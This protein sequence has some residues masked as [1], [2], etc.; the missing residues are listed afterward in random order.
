MVAVGEPRLRI[1]RSALGP[2]ATDVQ[3]AD[4]AELGQNP[5]RIIPAWRDFVNRH[6]GAGHRLRG[7]SEP[8]W[9]GRS[10]A[11]VIE[12]QLHEA[13]LNMAVPADTPLWLLC[14]YDVA[15]LDGTVI[16]EAHRSHPVVMQGVKDRASA[17]YGGAS[18]VGFMFEGALPAPSAS[19]IVV[20]VDCH[21]HGHVDKVMRHARTMGLAADR[22]VRLAA[23]VDEIAVAG[24]R[25][26]GDA[27]IRVWQEGAAVVCQIT[28]GGVV[29]NPMIGRSTNLSGRFSRNRAIR[30]ANELCDLVQVRSNLGGTTVRLHSSV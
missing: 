17:S 18:H 6:S 24:Y 9:A 28:D 5:A 4:M 11:E 23:A 16:D 15:T 22:T 19:S 7:V 13:L 30:L 8:I 12:Y 21:L 27:G 26:T 25:E 29:T 1:V 20:T 2:A 10:A 14:P 3:F